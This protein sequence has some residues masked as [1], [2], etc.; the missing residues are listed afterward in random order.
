VQQASQRLLKGGIM[1]AHPIEV[2]RGNTQK[3]KE[4]M[5]SGF[6]GA[7]Y[8]AAVRRRTPEERQ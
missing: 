6:A 8:N 7:P 2:Q 4:N 5:S 1:I 3:R